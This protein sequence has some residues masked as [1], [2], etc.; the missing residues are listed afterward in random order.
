MKKFVCSVCGYVHVRSRYPQN[1]L[2]AM[3]AQIS[4]STR[5]TANWNGLLNTL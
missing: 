3:L 2:F 1:V 5:R 4:S